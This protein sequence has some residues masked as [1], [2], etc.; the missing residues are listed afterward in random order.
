MTAQGLVAEVV[1][2]GDEL[3][4]AGLIVTNSSYLAGQ[5][6]RVGLTVQR[7]TVV[8][9][10]PDQL[11]GAIESACRRADLVVKKLILLMIE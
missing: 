4:H 11:Q 3:L 2:I 1:S 7:F 5:L 9:D 6:E 8:G 10:E